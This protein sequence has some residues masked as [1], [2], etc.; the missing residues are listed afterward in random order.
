MDASRNHSHKH[1]HG[2]HS[3]DHADGRHGHGVG[4]HTHGSIDPSIATS[5]RGI[6]AIKWSFVVLIITALIQVV[7]VWISS[8]VALLAD[9]IHNVADATTAIP[10]WVAF[11]LARRRR[12]ARFTFG[13]G[14]VEDL[15]GVT[16]VLIIAF[17]AIVAGYEAIQRFQNPQPI[18]HLWAVMVASVVGF[19][20]NEIVA[21]FRIRIGR[22]IKSA[23]L[24]AD[25]YHARVDAWTS[26]AVLLGALG[27]WLGFPFADPIVG[28]LISVAI[29]RVVWQSSKVVFARLLD[30]VE[31]HIIDE[32]RHTAAHAP[33]VEKVTD[34]RARWSGHRLR[35]ELDVVV[36]ADLS[37]TQG[38]TIAKEVRHR[39]SHQF[40]YLSSVVVHVDPT[41]EAGE[42]FHHVQEHSHDG[43]PLHSH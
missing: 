10:L 18:G 35:A 27:V 13:Y 12:S 28:L 26:L 37:V 39:L 40:A 7:V 5:A 14:R 25:G 23:A 9:T 34:V 38:H 41:Q 36:A 8:S 21:V 31:P 17:S 3:H 2:D 6:W 29:A 1:H 16:I 43:L 33:G 19:L 15:A 42:E 4:G 24:V 22:Q 11:V 32:I 30:G 20:G